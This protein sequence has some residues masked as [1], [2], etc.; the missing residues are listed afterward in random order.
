M[1]IDAIVVNAVHPARFR[2]DEVERLRGVTA[3]RP[4]TRAACPPLSPST[5]GRARSTLRC[6]ACG[7]ARARR[8]PRSRASSSPSSGVR[9]SSACLPS[10]SGGCD[11]RLARPQGGLHLRGLG[12]RRQD[13]HLGGDRAGDGRARQEGG[14]ADDRPREAARELARPAGARQRGAARE[15]R[16]GRRAVGDDARPQAHLR[17]DRRVARARRAHARRGAVEPDLP[18]AL[19]RRRRLAGVHGDGEAPRAPPGGPLRPARAR[20]AA[21]AQRARLHRRAEEAR[22]RSSTRARFRRSPGRACWG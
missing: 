16:R 21:H 11:R 14:G 20:H 18:G 6:D 22:R 17:R 13:D 8:S 12:R 1:A 10:W 9:S 15:G 19:E 2:R 4:V 3:D 5:G 7:G